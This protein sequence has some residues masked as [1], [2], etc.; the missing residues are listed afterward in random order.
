MIQQDFTPLIAIRQSL[1][2]TGL[3]KREG[4]LLA[5]LKNG[6]T[7]FSKSFDNDIEH[8]MITIEINHLKKHFCV[9][10]KPPSM[11]QD[12]FLLNLD[13]LLH[14]LSQIKEEILFCGDLD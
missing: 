14:D 13:S 8:L 6:L 9:L 7:A 1:P 12:T 5:L 11:N 3:V 10:Y 4:V 2:K